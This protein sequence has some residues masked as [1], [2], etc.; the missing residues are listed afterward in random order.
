PV[1]QIPQA[2]NVLKVN[3]RQAHRGGKRPF[4]MVGTDLYAG[5]RAEQLRNQRETA[6]DQNDRDE[7]GPFGARI[8]CVRGRESRLVAREVLRLAVIAGLVEPGPRI[9]PDHKSPETHRDDPDASAIQFHGAHP[10]FSPG[11]D[12][13]PLTGA[14]SCERPH[15][16]GTEWTSLPSR[17][18][19]S[20]FRTIA[21]TAGSLC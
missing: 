13:G 21:P 16:G 10:L 8:A 2:G 7:V 14:V 9:D 1:S 15:G 18:W 11:A 6:V 4:G 17:P 12:L 5:E 20:S 19:T 3:D